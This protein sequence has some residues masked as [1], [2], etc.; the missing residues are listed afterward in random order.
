MLPRF[1]F[2]VAE[3]FS[4]GIIYKLTEN[5]RNLKD[6]LELEKLPHSARVV[7]AGG[8]PWTDYLFVAEIRIAQEDVEK[9]LAGRAFEK[10]TWY[11]ETVDTSWISNSRPMKSE[12]AIAGP[13]EKTNSQLPARSRSVKIE[14]ESS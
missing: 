9:L 14:R 7:G 11:S 1:F 10:E 3:L 2:C 6:A 8:E 12:K 13:R 5:H 4:L